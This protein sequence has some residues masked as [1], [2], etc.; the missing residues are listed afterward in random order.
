LV[1]VQALQNPTAVELHPVEVLVVVAVVIQ[2]QKERELQ[3]RVMT[4][5]L[6]LRQVM[7]AAAELVR[8]VEM[9]IVQMELQRYVQVE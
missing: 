4:V 1:A 9:E 3:G 7:A 2:E 8:Q 6:Q 5:V